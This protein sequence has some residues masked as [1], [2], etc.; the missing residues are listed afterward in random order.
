MN[1]IM[2]MLMGNNNNP[3]GAIMGMFGGNAPDP[4]QMMGEFNQFA[5]NFSGDAEQKAKEMLNSGNINQQWFNQVAPMAMQMA[6]Q[7]EKMYG[8]NPNNI[9]K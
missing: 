7:F 4:N 8:S 9:Q 3:F 6:Q 1:P 5:S 2:N